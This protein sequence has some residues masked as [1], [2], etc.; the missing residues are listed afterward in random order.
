MKP[1]QRIPQGAT[2]CLQIEK[3]LDNLRVVPQYR[4]SL[5]GWS[6]TNSDKG[7]LICKVISPITLEHLKKHLQFL[8][9]P[10]LR[11]LRYF[12]TL[13]LSYPNHPMCPA[14]RLLH[15]CLM[16]WCITTHCRPQLETRLAPKLSQWRGVVGSPISA[17]SSSSSSISQFCLLSRSHPKLQT[18]Y[19]KIR[20]DSKIAAYLDW[21]C[22]HATPAW[23]SASVTSQNTQLCTLSLGQSP[24]KMLYFTE[25]SFLGRLGT[26]QTMEIWAH[27]STVSTLCHVP[28]GMLVD[29]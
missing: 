20:A 26:L 28:P 8:F 14:A 2:R 7:H 21:L 23:Q 16:H 12:Q 22:I 4:F 1:D 5:V 3:F 15:H 10:W 19:E 13:I 17:S 29:C 9:C 11:S 6:I 25:T 27:V 18:W 24:M